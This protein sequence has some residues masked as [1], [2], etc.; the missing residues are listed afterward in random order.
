[1]IT[2]KHMNKLDEI[3]LKYYLDRDKSHGIDHIQKVL[4]NTEKISE[5]F[6]F[7]TREKII[8]RACAL[9]HDAYDHKYVQKEEDITL[10]K[11]KISNDLTKFGIT[12][13][14]IQIIF[15]II[16][17]ISFS[18]EKKQ[19]ILQNYRYSE[20]L[21][22]LSPNMINI[23]NIVSDADKIEALGKEGIYRMILDSLH[24]FSEYNKEILIKLITD[25]IKQLC[26]NK[27]YILLSHN[28]IR[29]DIGREIAFQKLEELKEIKK[30]DEI[31]QKFVK[32][33]LK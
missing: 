33:F 16:D 10:V 21:S 11:V 18:K 5:Y 24:K 28:Y 31:L 25:D 13:N 1:M 17:N 15:I 30:N 23:R 14:E 8:L 20:L 32:Q 7:T 19:R 22:L 4:K 12:W 29:T 6:L 27:L 3:C 2:K 9:L 26:Q